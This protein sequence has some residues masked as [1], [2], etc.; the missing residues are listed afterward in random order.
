[1]LPAD[2]KLPPVDAVHCI[3]HDQHFS[4]GQHVIEP[5]IEYPVR[6]NFGSEFLGKFARQ[7]GNRIFTALQPTAR[8]LPFVPFVQEKY[9]PVAL[10]ED[11]P[12]T[13]TG[14]WTPPSLSKRILRS[15]RSLRA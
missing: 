9:G 8:Q 12:L 5:A 15:T 4:S 3:S 1:V 6:D 11:I 2:P 13:D 14:N 7:A 10:Q